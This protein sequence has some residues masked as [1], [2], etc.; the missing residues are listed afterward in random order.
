MLD[1]VLNLVIPN[2]ELYGIVGFSKTT[3]SVF[4]LQPQ[5]FIVSIDSVPSTLVVTRV[6]ELH[7]WG[8]HTF[9]MLHSIS[10]MDIFSCIRTDIAL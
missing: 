4:L 2:L 1:I 7:F 5:R 3:S 6:V 9:I 8:V 10:S